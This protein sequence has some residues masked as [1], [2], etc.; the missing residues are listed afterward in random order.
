MF[1]VYCIDFYTDGSCYW[2]GLEEN[3]KW[4]IVDSICLLTTDRNEAEKW[5]PIY[6]LVKRKELEIAMVD[7]YFEQ[8]IL[9]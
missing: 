4:K 2:R 3:G 5:H 7:W 6:D 1:T 8:G 9:V